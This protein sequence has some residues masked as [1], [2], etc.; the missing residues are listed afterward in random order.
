MNDLY[1]SSILLKKD[2]NL[3]IEIFLYIE[4][5]VLSMIWVKYT[6]K[7][8]QHYDAPIMWKR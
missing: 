5:I 6:P 8:P 4:D 3:Y 7:I 2:I 1:R